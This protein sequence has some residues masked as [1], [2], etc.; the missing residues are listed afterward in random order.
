VDKI[1]TKVAANG[2]WRRILDALGIPKKALTGKHQP[3]LFCGGKDRARWT[4]FHDDGGYYCN[5]CGSA[6]GFGLL[7]KFHG[8]TFAKAAAEVDRILSTNTGVS[9][10]RDGHRKKLESEEPFIPRAT[11][12]CALWLRRYRPAAELEAWLADHDPDVRWWL[13]TQS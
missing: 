6:D 1:T 3:C 2:R 11:R 7:M 9:L 8:W 13:E 10:H 4:N 5:Q 12:D